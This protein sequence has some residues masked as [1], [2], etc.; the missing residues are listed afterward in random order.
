MLG[1]FRRVVPWGLM[2]FGTALAGAE[3]D[4]PLTT[5]EIQALRREVLAERAGAIRFA[6][7]VPN[8]PDRLE[9]TPLFRY[10]DFT[11][12]YV[13]AFVWK[14]G[15]TG[16][17]R[18]IITNEL[19]PNYLGGGPRMVYDFLS[20]SPDPFVAKSNDVGWSPRGSAVHFAA[21]PEGP[22]PAANPAARLQQIKTLARR[23][24]ATQLIAETDETLVHLRLLPKEIDRYVP[25]THQRSDG[26]AF[27]FVNGRNPGLMLFLETDGTG[28]HYGIGRLS[29]PSTL[30]V[31]L[32][33][34]AVWTRPRG[35]EP[36]GSYTA[37]NSPANF[38]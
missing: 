35:S 10:D 38:P 37:S 12:G 24:T 36:D 19:H 26:A 14:L 15:A 22:E 33:D 27:L 21:I 30:T 23:F 2:I 11:R 8:F 32:D 6:A 3:P 7:Q 16:R 1:S 13:D 17:P 20:L 9:P 34:H 31:L 4:A 18:A 5:E 25:A 28:W 29:M